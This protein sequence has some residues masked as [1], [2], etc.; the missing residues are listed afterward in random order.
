MKAFITGASG[1]IGRALTAELAREGWEVRPVPRTEIQTFL[2]DLPES[3][4]D[5]VF[6][7]AG[8]TQ[9][10][11]AALLYQA[12]T[13]LTARLL[14]AIAAM[15]RPPRIVLSGSAAEYGLVPQQ[16]V[17]VVEEHP[18]NPVSDYATSKYSQ[19]LMARWRA[20]AGANLVTARI[21]N[22]V[23]PGMP[24]HLAL[25]SF[26][27]QIVAMPAR[28][29]VLNVGNL[30]VERDFIDVAEVARI[31]MELGR[32]KAARGRVFNVC[33]G[34]A[35]KLRDLVDAMIDLSG[36]AITI[37]LD[38]SRLRPGETM[39]LFGATTRLRE[40][41]IDPAAPDFA[42]LLPLILAASA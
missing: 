42:A 3:G 14:D 35:W 4:A 9:S 38:Q 11:E 33:S 19:T 41:G 31:L 29:G 28:G 12:N 10:G 6:H 39:R 34:Q 25:A 18:C 17:P 24:R 30:D 21:W 13:V 27:A 40:L 15:E 22:P 20:A 26:A 23:G 36:R 2:H 37:N 16:A 1:F 5:V 32:H 8:M 7:L